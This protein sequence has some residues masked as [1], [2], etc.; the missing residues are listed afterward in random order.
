MQIFKIA[1]LSA[2]LL[3]VVACCRL[4]P[5]ATGLPDNATEIQ[6]LAQYPDIDEIARISEMTTLL[7]GH[8][9]HVGAGSTVQHL[10]PPAMR[11]IAEALTEL[12]PQP[13]G[14]RL[15]LRIEDA[16]K[17]IPYK[18][19][20]IKLMTDN[21][22][23][24]DLSRR[25]RDVFKVPANIEISYA[26]YEPPTGQG[27]LGRMPLLRFI[28][29]DRPADSDMKIF[30]FLPREPKGVLYAIIGLGQINRIEN[31]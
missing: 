20:G 16:T 25:L 2:S 21:D 6:K 3:A 7:M 8:H 22:T 5:A 15:Y 9:G 11:Q 17:T 30:D 10:S 26:Y 24:D 13:R 31:E 14:R 29:P 18:R 27:P 28:N 12:Y 1:L 4:Y 23:F 19:M